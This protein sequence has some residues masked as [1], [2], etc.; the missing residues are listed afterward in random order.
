MITL[1][2]LKVQESILLEQ[3]CQKYELPT[4]LVEQ[5]LKSSEKFTYENVPDSVR[6]KDYLD[7][8]NFYTK[9]EK[10]GQ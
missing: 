6:K 10:G 1:N 9:S 2:R 7:L 4:K 8:I 5:L 3:I